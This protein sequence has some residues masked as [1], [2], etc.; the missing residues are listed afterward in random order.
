[1]AFP[2]LDLVEGFQWDKGNSGKNDDKHGI[3]D[4]PAEQVLFNKPVL[5]DEPK[6]S[7]L[8]RR[9]HA[10]GP[11]DDGRMLHVSFTLRG[12]GELIR[13]ISARPLNRKERILYAKEA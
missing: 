3:S 6:H 1:M 5:L 13:V 9:F 2:D 12:D 11:A 7:A 4:R 8:E 10:L